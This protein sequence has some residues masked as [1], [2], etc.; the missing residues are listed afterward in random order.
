MQLRSVRRLYLVNAVIIPIVVAI[1]P[2]W[3][4]VITGLVALVQLLYLY[5]EIVDAAK[6]ATLEETRAK[7]LKRQRSRYKT[8]SEYVSADDPSR[9]AFHQ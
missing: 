4:Q 6:D 5:Q 2:A 1:S 9:P 7:V 3:L 8:I